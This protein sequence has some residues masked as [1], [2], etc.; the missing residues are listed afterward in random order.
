MWG[1]LLT[2]QAA[3]VPTPGRFGLEHLVRASLPGEN[4]QP[5]AAIRVGGGPYE[6]YFLGG[7]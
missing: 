3:S 1:A 4:V 5:P 2:V 6:P 7:Q